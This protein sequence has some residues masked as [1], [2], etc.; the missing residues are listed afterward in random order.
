MSKRTRIETV[1][2]VDKETGEV[3]S[4]K[5]TSFRVRLPQEDYCKLYFDVVPSISSKGYIV[6][7]YLLKAMDYNNKVVCDRELKDYIYSK[8]GIKDGYFRKIIWE[9]T[10][11]NV[12]VRGA[13]STYMINP[14]IAAKASQIKV[15]EL[16]T[17]YD[18]KRQPFSY[19]VI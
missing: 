17:F 8:T 16:K 13:F 18:L 19:K 2:E 10:K 14:N 5:E 3:L 9:L 15:E 12:I 4:V 11:A 1:T 7:I 6:L